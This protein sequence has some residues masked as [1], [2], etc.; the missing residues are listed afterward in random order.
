MFL[1]LIR[2]TTAL[3]ATVLLAVGCGGGGSA[4]PPK[5]GLAVTSATQST[6]VVTWNMTAGVEYWLF[7]GPTSLAPTGTTSADKWIGILGG[8][9]IIKA[10]SPATIPGLVNGTQYSFTINARTGGGPGGPVATPVTVTPQAAGSKWVAATP[11]PMGTADLRGMTVGTAV[12]AVGAKGAM[13]ASADT[14]NW[15]PINPVTTN[16]LNAVAWSTNYFAV[17]DSGT[18]LQSTDAI[19]WTPRSSGL[20]KNLYGVATN[21]SLTVAVGAGG[22]IITSADGITWTAATT[23]PATNDLLSV[24][25]LGAA[26][27]AV[28]AGGT[29]MYSSDGL[30]WVARN[31]NTTSD[32]RGVTYGV[33]SGSATGAIFVAG[34]ANGTLVTSTDGLTWVVQ[35][36]P[37]TTIYA[38][39]LGLQFVAVGSGG[40]IFKSADG[41]SWT[42]MDSPTTND[43]LA[44]RYGLSSFMAVGANGTNLYSH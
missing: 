14:I 28:G 17:G 15:G 31:T 9:T 1:R 13:Y 5:E 20:T 40:K 35:T 6:A 41:L 22:T 25:Y 23:N 30:T 18:I 7:Y 37:V 16:N 19:T 33:S 4:E 27:Y 21:G 44:V 26:W 12:V 11:N 2:L 32:L 24:A 29:L 43:L 38:V 8:N 36:L 34:G 42:A 39:D 3:L 10:T